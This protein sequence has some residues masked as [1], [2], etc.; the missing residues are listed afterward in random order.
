MLILRDLA[1][2]VLFVWVFID[3]MV[4]YWRMSKRVENRDRSS[5]RLL[6]IAGPLLWVVSIG[7]AFTAMGRLQAPVLQMVGLVLMGDRHRDP[8]DCNS[9]VGTFAY[10]ERGGARGPSGEGH[11]FVSV[12]AA[13]EL[14][15]RVDRFCGLWVRSG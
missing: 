9:A 10:T 8:L 15:R 3:G 4:V 2:T 11:R 6:M 5:L 1:I 13:P 14:S 12:R 7:L